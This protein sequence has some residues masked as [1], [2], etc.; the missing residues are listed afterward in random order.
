M[1]YDNQISFENNVFNN[2]TTLINTSYESISLCWIINLNT[3]NWSFGFWICWATHVGNIFRSNWGINFCYKGDIWKGCCI[4]ETT[5][6]RNCHLDYYWITRLIPYSRFYKCVGYYL[7]MILA[8]TKMWRKVQCSFS[9]LGIDE[10]WVLG[11]LLIV[12][13]GLQRSLFMISITN[14]V[15]LAI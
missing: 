13:V 11:L 5:M 10:L 3:Q 7:L 4:C 2:F 12:D 15:K 1:F 6:L 9:N 8:T 14:N